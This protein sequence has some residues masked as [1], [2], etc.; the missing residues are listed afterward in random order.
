MSEFIPDKLKAVTTGER[1]RLLGDDALRGKKFS[2]PAIIG[3]GRVLGERGIIDQAKLII[4]RGAEENIPASVAAFAQLLTTTTTTD[5]DAIAVDL[6]SRLYQARTHERS[7]DPYVHI[8]AKNDN[9]A[10][11]VRIADDQFAEIHLTQPTSTAP[12]K[13]FMLTASTREVSM[14]TGIE[15]GPIDTPTYTED[16]TYE[17]FMQTW[18]MVLESIAAVQDK[19][20]PK[21]HTIALFKEAYRDEHQVVVGEIRQYMESLQHIRHQAVPRL[22]SKAAVEQ[23]QRQ[24]A[25]ITIES[26]FDGIVGLDDVKRQLKETASILTDHEAATK[27]GIKTPHFFLYG[28]SGTAK[29]GLLEAF[30]RGTSST[31]ITINGTEIDSEYYG[32]GAKNLSAVFDRAIGLIGDRPVVI[33]MDN[34]D[35]L[36]RARSDPHGHYAA[37][38]QAFTEK[39]D[40]ITQK[41]PNRIIVIGATTLQPGEMDRAVARQGRLKAISVPTP[42]QKEREKIWDLALRK[43]YAVSEERP[44]GEEEWQNLIGN[45]GD[46]EFEGPEPPSVVPNPAR[47]ASITEEMV[48]ATIFKIVD[49]ALT[50]TFIAGRRLPE[51]RPITQATLERKIDELRRS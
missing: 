44:E 16:S 21:S 31:A 7:T 9:L 12:G 48:G 34:I 27:Y 49:E 30:I 35:R 19:H 14:T 24:Q 3:H 32:K 47:L 8:V 10:N 38:V 13:V 18:G 25:M 51:S 20:Q 45:Y 6:Q 17:A 5:M 37:I 2:E 26:A 41:H 28:P 22:L 43:I 15:V 46:L 40:E 29:T 50:E 39:L 33:L 11:Y 1:V 36:L 4:L 42:T 23:Y